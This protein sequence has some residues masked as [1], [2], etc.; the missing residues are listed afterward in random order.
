MYVAHHDEKRQHIPANIFEW[1][2]LINLIYEA[3]DNIHYILKDSQ[4]SW[5]SDKKILVELLDDNSQMLKFILEKK[6]NIKE[7]RKN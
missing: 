5:D 3:F 4:V 1:K 2:K 7:N 6:D